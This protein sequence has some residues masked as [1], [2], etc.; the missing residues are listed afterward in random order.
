MR[1]A[2]RDPIHLAAYSNIISSL[3]KSAR[4]Q[5][6]ARLSACTSRF[7]AVDPRVCNCAAMILS[8]DCIVTKIGCVFGRSGGV[9]ETDSV[10]RLM[11]VECLITNATLN[12]TAA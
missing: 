5:N 2:R 10:H 12:A 6:L 7:S 9:I 1:R 11:S 3:S 4:P 8:S